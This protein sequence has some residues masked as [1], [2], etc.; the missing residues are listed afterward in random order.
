MRLIA[1]LIELPQLALTWSDTL[2]AIREIQS[3]FRP[4]VADACGFVA[5]EYRNAVRFAFGACINLGR[6]FDLEAE[7]T[8]ATDR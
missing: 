1:W 6:A 8:A 5:M 2:C 4:C 3:G 7:I